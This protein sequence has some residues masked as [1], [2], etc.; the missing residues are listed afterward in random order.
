MNWGL[1]AKHRPAEVGLT[2]K[3]HRDQRAPHTGAAV[4]PLFIVSGATIGS[5]ARSA[6]AESIT[7]TLSSSVLGTLGATSSA[8]TNSLPSR[9]CLRQ[10]HRF[11]SST[12]S[13]DGNSVHSEFYAAPVPYRPKSRSPARSVYTQFYSGA[14]YS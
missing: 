12:K 2:G 5:G 14:L 7:S 8:G 3:L 10:P 1:E 6:N 11:A 4:G 13:E 9:Y